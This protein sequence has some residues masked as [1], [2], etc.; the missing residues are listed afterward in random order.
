MGSAC[1]V[2][3]AIPAVSLVL[4][5]LRLELPRDPTS[6]GRFPRGEARSAE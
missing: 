3:Q 1:R 4:V 5:V 2:L 6:E